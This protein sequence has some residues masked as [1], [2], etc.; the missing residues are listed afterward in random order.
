MTANPSALTNTEKNLWNAIVS[1]AL[2]NLKYNAYAQRAMQ[3]GH[4]EVA[5]IFQE[6]AGAE[7]V[8]GINHLRVSGDMATTAENLRAII[9][10]EAQEAATIYPRMI[11]EA[12]EDGNQEAADSFTMAM[13]RERRHLEAFTEALNGLEAKLAAQ[14][15][16]TRPAPVP[17]IPLMPA[18]TSAAYSPV[19]DGS[20]EAEAAAERAF[21]RETYNTAV[22]EVDRERW[23]VA[24]LGRLREVVFGT[25]D[26][27]LSMVALVTSLAV[28]VE[29]QTTI[30]IAGLA[31]ALPGMISMST[32]AFLG[33][34]AEQDV[35]RAEIEREAREL[36]ENPAEE[37]AELVVL[38]QR[39]GMTYQDARHMADE[40]AQD[41]EL[42]LKT[43]VEKELGISGDVTSSPLKDALVMGLAF[44][45]GAAVPLV[46][47]FFLTG[48]QAIGV[49]VGAT[50]AG[51]FAL[52]MYKGRMVQRSPLLQGLEI[53]GIGTLSAGIGYALGELIPRLFT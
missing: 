16:G 3:E 14:P 45:V 31:G 39:E 19:P 42:W 6:V 1:E 37:L 46:P 43:L 28:A 13:E 38:L 20:S 5:Q 18:S 47:H 27:L 15:G 44:I 32:G 33:S 17:E 25:Q 2:A 48:G 29:S 50:L 7:T 21:D 10:G 35:Q 23:R 12:L 24:R 11:R 9:E 53:L 4:P 51:L 36:E 41:R 30:L 26:G 8:H 40:I 49:S 34:R 52:G 22:S